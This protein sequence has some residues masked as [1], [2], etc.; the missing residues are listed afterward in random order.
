MPAR[1][2]SILRVLFVAVG[3]AFLIVAFRE[4]WDR[5]VD[6]LIPSLPSLIGGGALVFLGI[7]VAA[8]AWIRLLADK[9]AGTDLLPGFYTAQ[10]G[11][12]I[13]GMIWQAVGQVGL[14]RSAGVR[15]GRAAAAFPVSLLTQVVAG[16]TIGAAVSLVSTRLP[17]PARLLPCVGVLSLALLRRSWMTS[18]LARAGGR[19]RHLPSDDVVPT[20]SAILGAYRWNLASM[21]FSSSGFA[22]LAASLGLSF[23]AA[24]PGFALAW[25]LGFLAVPFPAGIGVRE[26]VLVALLGGG[27]LTALVISAAVVYRLLSILAELTLFLVSRARR[28]TPGANDMS[29]PS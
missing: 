4:T 17:L 28:I 29:H 2:G 26:G 12:Y 7:A 9:G 15:T 13:P 16:A 24:V 21:L 8:R 3:L 11:K 6:A 20:Q 14:A 5:S 25:T 18:M 1:I 23:S 19:F 10:L 27:P 22:L